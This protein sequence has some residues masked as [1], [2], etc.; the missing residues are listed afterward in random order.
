MKHSERFIM[1][2][3]L[4][5]RLKPQVKYSTSCFRGVAAVVRRSIF[6]PLRN[7]R[8]LTSVWVLISSNSIATGQTEFT[9]N[10]I[11]LALFC[12]AVPL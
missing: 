4:V 11:T 5:T 10:M 3:A 1:K 6:N 2:N 7:T 9:P 8:T 12:S